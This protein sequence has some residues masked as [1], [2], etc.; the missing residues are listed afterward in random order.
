MTEMTVITDGIILLDLSL[1]ECRQK[2]TIS[3]KLGNQTTHNSLHKLEEQ[4][5]WD[6]CGNGVLMGVTLAQECIKAGHQV[7]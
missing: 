1:I 7:S 3:Q 4:D 6:A 2:H 5:P